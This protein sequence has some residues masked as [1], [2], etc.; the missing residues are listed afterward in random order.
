MIY[1]QITS[2]VV[3]NAIVLDDVSLVPTFTKGFDSCIR[4]DNITDV[5]GNPIGIGWT[6]DGSNFTAPANS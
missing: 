6:Y 5:A 4:I 3:M 1:A 2:G